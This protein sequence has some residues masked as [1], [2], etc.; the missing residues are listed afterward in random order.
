LLRQVQ[1]DG[2]DRATD[3]LTRLA[4]VDVAR[5][6]DQFRA[7][8]GERLGNAQPDA[9]RAACH[10]HSLAAQIQIHDQPSIP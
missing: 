7:L 1:I 6:K 5:D 8:G 2:R 10:Q 3:L 9:F 4:L